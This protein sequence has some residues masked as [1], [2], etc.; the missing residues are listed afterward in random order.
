MFVIA[1]PKWFITKKKCMEREVE[2]TFLHNKR[3]EGPQY[4]LTCCAIL[5]GLFVLVS[6][7]A[8]T[9]P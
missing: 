3:T 1:L 2:P 6:F 7:L 8:S 5:L 9:R 4:F